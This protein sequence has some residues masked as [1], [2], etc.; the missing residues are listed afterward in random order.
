VFN[1]WRKGSKKCRKKDTPL[2]RSL[3]IKKLLSKPPTDGATIQ[4]RV[5]LTSKERVSDLFTKSKSPF[6]IL[7]DAF[8]REGQGKILIV[9]KEHIVWVEPEED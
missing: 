4:G 9:N 7:V 3:F 5:N 1:I 6:I 8:L 2:T